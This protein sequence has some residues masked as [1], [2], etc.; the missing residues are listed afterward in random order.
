MLQHLSKTIAAHEKLI[1][2][3][4]SI[5]ALF[6]TLLQLEDKSLN[7][8][9]LHEYDKRNIYY[10]LKLM[11]LQLIIITHMF[12]VVFCPGRLLK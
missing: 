8:V 5:P 3:N 11:T 4:G 10:N 2:F 12:V 9:I 6:S 1:P 7:S